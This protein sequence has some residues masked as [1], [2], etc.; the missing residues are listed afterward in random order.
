M[1]LYVTHQSG[2]MEGIFN[3]EL[4]RLNLH[5]I[6]NCDLKH[7]VILNLHCIICILEEMIF[8]VFPQRTGAS[9][10]DQ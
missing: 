4:K 8:V 5:P 2:L 9:I 3:L 1:V 7:F 10:M 6:S